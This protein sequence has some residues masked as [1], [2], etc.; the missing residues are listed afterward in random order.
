MDTLSTLL[1]E[2]LQLIET[3]T[4]IACEKSAASRELEKVG[5]T[6]N[7]SAQVEVLSSQLSLQLQVFH[8]VAYT[9]KHK[10]RA[11]ARARAGV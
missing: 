1:Q 3:Q 11:R 5:E 9:H 10:A 2:Q 4:K 7:L 6:E 8:F